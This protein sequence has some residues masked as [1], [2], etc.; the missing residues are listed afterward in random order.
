MFLKN[1]KDFHILGTQFS[2]L[3]HFIY[4]FKYIYSI[5][6]YVKVGNFPFS[7]HIVFWAVIV[8]NLHTVLFHEEPAGT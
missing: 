1:S 2:H 5:D 6:I 3:C 7:N 4:L 8:L